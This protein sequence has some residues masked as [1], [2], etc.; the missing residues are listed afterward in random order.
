[1]VPAGANLGAVRDRIARPRACI[2]A[3][4]AKI[5]AAAGVPYIFKASYDKANRSSGKSY[6]GPGMEQGWR[7]WRRSRRELGLPVLT[8]I[9]TEDQIAAVAEVVDVLQ[10][11]AFLCRQTD[12]LLAAARTGKPVNVKKGQFLAPWDMKNVVE[13]VTRPGTR[14]CC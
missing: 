8:D 14:A 1:M 9:H 2:G 3:Q 10:I 5:A 12:F 6:R 4:I 7:S 11:P 13:K